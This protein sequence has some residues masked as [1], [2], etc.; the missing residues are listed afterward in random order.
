MTKRTNTTSATA[1]FAGGCF[2]CIESDFSNTNGIVEIVSGY[3]GGHKSRPRYEE[4]VTGRTG[5]LEAVQIR[6]DERI[7]GY[8]QLLDIF[9]RHV[10]PTDAGGQ[11]VD[12]GS[13][14][15]SA[16]FYH[17]DRQKRLAEKSRQELDRSRRFGKPVVTQI[18]PFEKF[19]PAESFHQAYYKKNPVRYKSYR[20]NSGRD[21]FLRSAWPQAGKTAAAPVSPDNGDGGNKPSDQTLRRRLTDL[22]YRVTRKE[23]TEPPFDNPY[24]NNKDEGIYVDIVSG[25]PLF[26]STDKYDSATGWP[27]FVRPLEPDNLVQKQDHRSLMTRTEVR[28][29]QADSHLGHVFDDGPQPTGLR[30]CINSAALRFIP[31]EKLAEEGYG[32]YLTLF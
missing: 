15:R 14:Y 27:S 32:R 10:D 21:Q 31:K 7:I 12:R 29:R 20:S 25:E 1:T 13:Q 6:Y 3:T 23:A 2:W 11:F 5:H 24:W 28:S 26:S 4:V 30:Y 9:W 8:E 17:D 16:I 18:L 22:Q 19:Y